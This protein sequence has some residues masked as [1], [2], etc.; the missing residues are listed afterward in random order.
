MINFLYDDQPDVWKYA[1]WGLN[2]LQE[3]F[4]KD[5]PEQCTQEVREAAVECVGDCGLASSRILD[6]ELLYFVA[7]NS[8][9]S[10]VRLTALEKMETPHPLEGILQSSSEDTVRTLVTIN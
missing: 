3:R 9:L 2:D 8:K 6:E 10:A 7:L 4:R 1:S 5:V